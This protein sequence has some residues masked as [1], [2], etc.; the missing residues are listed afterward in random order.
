MA[1]FVTQRRMLCATRDRRRKRFH[2]N[3]RLGGH[4]LEE[5]EHQRQSMSAP[6]PPFAAQTDCRVWGHRVY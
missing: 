5:S 1:R 4:V 3:Q 2:T 6:E